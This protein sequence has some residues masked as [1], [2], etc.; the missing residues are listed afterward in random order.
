MNLSVLH[1]MC[2]ISRLQTGDLLLNLMPVRRISH[3]VFTPS[4]ACHL[5]VAAD[6]LVD[7][8]SVRLR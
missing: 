2:E 4:N 8:D 1:P 5:M 6:F 7:P 3:L